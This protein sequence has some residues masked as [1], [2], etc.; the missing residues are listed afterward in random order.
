MTALR[1]PA[2]VL[3]T[4]PR[5]LGRKPSAGETVALGW[6]D[7]DSHA[8]SVTIHPDACPHEE[9]AALHQLAA[10]GA[11]R[12][13]VVAYTGPGDGS[14]NVELAASL[15]WMEAAA[16][17]YGLTVYDSLIVTRHR[18]PAGA[19]W[20]SAGCTNP[21]CCPPEGTPLVEEPSTP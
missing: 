3:S 17:R 8:V 16:G 5:V 12:V 20:R 13:V 7:D 9:A 1:G 19:T 2:A 15:R 11:T 10:D 18:P 6:N 21:S 4:L 14:P